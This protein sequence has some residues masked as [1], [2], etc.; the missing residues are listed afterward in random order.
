M[1]FVILGTQDKPFFRLLNELEK[2]IKANNIKD[3]IIVQTGD[4]NYESNLFKSFKYIDNAGF[5]EYMDKADI[6][7]THA[8]SGALFNAI[9]KGKKIIAIAR[10]K[11]YGEMVDDNQTELV[12]KLAKDGYIIDGTYSLIDAWKLLDTFSPRSCDFPN[13]IVPNLKKYIDTLFR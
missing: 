13:M 2:L 7:I 8:G 11:R 10:L 4:T 1:I 5:I 6:I 9:K 12:K 3:D